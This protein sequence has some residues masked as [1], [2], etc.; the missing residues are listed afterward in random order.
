[1]PGGPG[2]PADALERVFEPFYSADGTRGAGLGLAIAHELA[3]QMGA[4][5]DVSSAPGDT[6][7]TL[8]LLTG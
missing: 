4:R 5:L 6:T 8:I 2:I 3:L 1:M 7:F